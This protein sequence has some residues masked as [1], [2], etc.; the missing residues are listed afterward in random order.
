MP[1]DAQR[2]PLV[3]GIVGGIGAG[4][5]AVARLL[6]THGAAVIDSDTI[7]K[8]A[9]D[10]EDVRDAL[11]SWWGDEVLGADGRIDRQAVGKIV[12]ADDVERRKLESL[13]HPLVHAARA[14]AITDAAAA[15]VRAVVVDAPLLFEA[16]V[17]RECDVVIFVDVPRE[18]RLARVASRGWDEAE[19][20]RREAAQW[21][22]DRKRAASSHV[23]ENAGSEAD[24]QRA[25]RDLWDSLPSP[26][27]PASMP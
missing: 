18:T 19:L 10:R 14:E 7:A 11:V 21:P 15:G 12:F 20:D 24:L 16:G 6:A 9:L 27:A 25:V 4:K 1:E 8:A 17:D 5:S 3:I 23:I 2:R 13:V 26:P 22:I